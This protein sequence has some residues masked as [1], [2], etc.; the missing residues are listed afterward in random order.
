[1][2]PSA[3]QPLRWGAIAFVAIALALSIADLV[4]PLRAWPVAFVAMA[5]ALMAA[6]QLERTRRERRARRRRA[7]A[8]VLAPLGT[9]AAVTAPT[10]IDLLSQG[11][12]MGLTA[13][14]GAMAVV[15]QIDR[16]L[17]GRLGW[18][19]PAAFTEAVAFGQSIPGAI[20][21]NVLA[22]LGYRLGGWPGAILLEGAYVLPSFLLMLVFGLAYEWLRGL[23]VTDAALG[24]L[25]PAV[26]AVVAIVAY[27]L[28]RRFLK[29]PEPMTWRRAVWRVRG[30]ILVALAATVAVA[31]LGFGAPEVIL[32]CGF[33]SLA[34]SVSASR[35]TV[36]MPVALPA[37]PAVSHASRMDALVEVLMV[38]LRTGATTFGGGYVM[39]PVLERELV[40]TGWIP[41]REFMDAVAL[42]QITPGPV[43]I[44]ASFIG[45]RLAGL[46]GALFGTVAVFA[47]SFLIAMA[48]AGS[49]D[50]I[51][52]HPAMKAF[53]AGV[54]PAIV[55]VMT[56]AVVSLG[57]SGIHGWV[58]IAIAAAGFALLVVTQI[59]TGVVLIGAAVLGV[60]LRLLGVTM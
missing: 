32:F 28:W 49:V 27:N 54:Q 59:G 22:L 46:A 56:A 15:A 9:S 40:K 44:T 7:A 29:P 12:R 16:E 39:V 24:G 30:G 45:Y 42:G 53:L 25:S 3:R 26:V 8:E 51:R 35:L 23:A 55:G 1:M 14:G 19:S 60:A 2:S 21:N 58:G 52:N 31:W 47:P 43:T 36:L 57:R 37:L 33:A 38:F 5:L 50:R 48:V 17:V 41:A 20:A 34:W 11:L 6:N 4:H 13:F 18:V 10:L